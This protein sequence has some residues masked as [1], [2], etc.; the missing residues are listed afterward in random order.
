MPTNSY[1]INIEWQDQFG[2]WHHF[3]QRSNQQ[4]AFRSAQQRA[5]STQKRHR[6]IDSNKN[7]LDILNP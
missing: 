4:A 2:S 7:I 1:A 5:K 3:Q 6:L